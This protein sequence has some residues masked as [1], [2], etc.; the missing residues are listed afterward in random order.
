MLQRVKNFKKCNMTPL[1]LHYPFHDK[2]ASKYCFFQLLSFSLKPKLIWLSNLK[3]HNKRYV[4]FVVWV[5]SVVCAGR[6]TPST[7]VQR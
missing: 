6:I 5:T 2:K 7:R 3:I 1:H 4:A